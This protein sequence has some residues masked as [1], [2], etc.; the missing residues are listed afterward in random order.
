MTIEIRIPWFAVCLHSCLIRY[1]V[2]GLRV[3]AFAAPILL[4]SGIGPST[5]RIPPRDECGTTGLM[6]SQ[7]ARGITT[8]MTG[9]VTRVR[10]D[11]LRLTAWDFRGGAARDQSGFGRTEMIDNR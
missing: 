6:V 8:T 3:S 1:S 11:G 5:S 4:L 2:F 9:G 7:I 10:E